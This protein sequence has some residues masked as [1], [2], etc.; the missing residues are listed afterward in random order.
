MHAG[1]THPALWRV[2]RR[3]QRVKRPVVA[4]GVCDAFTQKPAG[5][6]RSAAR[7]AAWASDTTP[8]SKG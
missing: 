1:V 3:Y 7:L 2:L 8:D 4:P 5:L 6:A